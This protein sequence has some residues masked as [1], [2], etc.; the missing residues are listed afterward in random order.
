MITYNQANSFSIKIY[1]DSLGI[2]PA[3]DRGYYGMY[4]SPFRKDQHASLKVDYDKNVWFDFGGN[5]G[6]TLIDLVM[7]INKCSPLQALEEVNNYVSTSLHQY[8]NTT[9]RQQKSFSFH[10]NNIDNRTKESEIQ[11]GEVLELRNPALV[12]YLNKRNID[13]EIARKY[14]KEV[15]YS[16]NNKFYFAIGFQNDSNGWI[17][18]N[19]YFKGCTSMDIRTCTK[20]RSKSDANKETCLLFEGFMDFLSYL[21]LKRGSETKHDVIVLNSVVS[22]K[23]AEKKLSTYQTIYAFLDN[24]EGGKRAIEQLQKFCKDVRDQSVHYRNYKD[25]NDYLCS[26]STSKQVVKKKQTRGRRM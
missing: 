6:G 13:I 4:R 16:V 23:K 24:D 18:R 25:L 1:L 17:L 5:D 21:A 19:E 2:Y 15:H 26:R 14:C 7:Q 8:N 9:V 12:A 11:I 10:G 22:L 20:T 3:K